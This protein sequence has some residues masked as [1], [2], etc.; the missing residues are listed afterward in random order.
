MSQALSL[1]SRIVAGSRVL[2]TYA[3]VAGTVTRVIDRDGALGGLVEVLRDGETRR[4]R[5]FRQAGFEA[6]KAVEL[7]G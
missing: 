1:D 6:G 2:I 4:S 7:I 5:R 3:G